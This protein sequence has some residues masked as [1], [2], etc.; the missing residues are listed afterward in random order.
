MLPMC[1]AGDARS[2]GIIG[3]MKRDPGTP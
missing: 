3:I 2:I 1:S